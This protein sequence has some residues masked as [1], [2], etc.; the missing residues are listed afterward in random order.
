MSTENVALHVISDCCGCTEY[1]RYSCQRQQVEVEFCHTV[2]NQA[3][4]LN[5]LV[6]AYSKG[7]GH[8][9]TL[10]FGTE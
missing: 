10:L 2:T 4:S 5:K 9:R 7:P 1:I 6:V 3:F 8:D